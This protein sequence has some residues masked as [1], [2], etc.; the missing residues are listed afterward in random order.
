MVSGITIPLMTSPPPYQP[1]TLARL[2]P[3]LVDADVFLAAVAEHL[4][5]RDG[6]GAPGWS[7]DRRLYQF[8]FPFNTGAARV[9]AI[10][11]APAAFRKPGRLRRPAGTGGRV[12]GRRPTGRPVAVPAR[13]QPRLLPT[14]AAAGKCVRG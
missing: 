4:A 6:R 10:V 11:H 3:L 1:L 9:G 13:D 7:E 8:W 5:A 12:T 14:V 2:A